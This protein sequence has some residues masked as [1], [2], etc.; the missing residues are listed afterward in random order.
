[1]KN[2]RYQI[3]FLTLIFLFSSC[4]WIPSSQADPAIQI[5][6][7][8]LSPETLMPGDI[9]VLTLTIRNAETT[10]TET[11]V[12]IAG[13]DTTTTTR[14]IGATIREI[15]IVAARSGNQQISATGSY[16]NVGYLAPGASIEVSFV[17]LVDSNM[18]E[19][20]HFLIAE[21]DVSGYTNVKYPIPI[22]VSAAE[23]ILLP[24]AIPSKVS[25]GGSTQITVTAVN[26][27]GSPVSDV[28]ISSLDNESFEFEPDVAYIGSVAASTSIATT[29][30]LKPH[31]KGSTNVSFLL[32]YKNGENLHTSTLVV[33]IEFIET[34]DVAPIIT[35]FP[36][37]IT[38]DGSSRITVEVYNA[39]TETITGVLV[40]PLC[41]ATVIP[42]Q[43]F[44]GSMDPDDVFSASFDIHADTVD[45]GTETISFTV[46]FKQGNDYY[47]TPLVSKTFEV[48]SGPGVS[49]Q[50]SGSYSGESSN[51]MFETP[52]LTVCLTVFFIIIS[53]F[54]IVVLLIIRWRKRRKA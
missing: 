17:L 25:L 47:E 30:S 51:G 11:T 28:M 22:T 38:K 42:S 36:L 40:T 9:A 46:S 12:T 6:S 35:N 27:R 18:S 14:T 26:R 49:Y 8:T 50:S 15:K 5:S 41:N 54:V 39:K 3:L 20:I 16:K 1:M 44:I 52:S 29:F 45:F 7:Y 24:T 33:P 2:K 31:E 13:G 32:S 19:G 53:I 23:V 43:Y 10:S 4:F 37:S 34:L 48:V 21:V